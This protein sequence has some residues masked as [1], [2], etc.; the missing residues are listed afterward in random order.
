MG[1]YDSGIMIS[2]RS[3][4]CFSLGAYPKF[5]LKKRDHL[6]AD[7]I[8][9]LAKLGH[10]FHFGTSGLG[11]IGKTQVNQA[12]GGQKHG[13]LT[14]GLIAQGNGQIKLVL[15]KFIHGFRALPADINAKFGHDL[16]SP[17]IHPGGSHPGGKGLNLT[18]EVMIDQAFRHLAATGIFRA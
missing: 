12:V 2:L 7:I 17:G 15:H 18:L 5:L 10:N 14:L 4:A 1:G 6:S 9:H 13:A 16:D 11:R 8:P 3:A